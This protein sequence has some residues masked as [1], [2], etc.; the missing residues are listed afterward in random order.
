MLSI[1]A[2]PCEVTLHNTRSAGV[3]TN[4]SPSSHLISKHSLIFTLRRGPNPN[5]ALRPGAFCIQLY[6]DVQYSSSRHSHS[7]L[8]RVTPWYKLYISRYLPHSRKS[9][10]SIWICIQEMT[11]GQS[12]FNLVHLYVYIMYVHSCI[13]H[14]GEYEH[15]PGICRCFTLRSRILIHT[16]PDQTTHH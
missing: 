10:D 16:R 9:P 13:I 6:T 2:A 3:H 5:S 4:Q 1:P 15:F 12:V 11:G 7:E 14:D 8:V